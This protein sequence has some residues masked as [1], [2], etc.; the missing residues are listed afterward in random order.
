MMNIAI[1]GGGAMGSVYAALLGS[2]GHAIT[3]LDRN[4]E[5]VRAI[6]AQG[7]RL[8][9]PLGD[10][11]VRVT[12]TL[13]APAV[14]QDLVVLAV[15]AA[16]VASAIT[17]ARPLLGTRTVVLT[18]QNGLGSAD[19]VATLLGPDGGARLAIGIASGFG[20]SLKGLGHAHHNAMQAIRLGAYAGLDRG[21]LDRVAATWRTAGFDA[22]AVD[23]IVA[24][25][26]RKLICNVAYSAP[27]AL[28]GLTVGAVMDDPELGPL[29]RAA[30]R[31]A[32]QVATALGV[33]IA[34]DDPDAHVRA[35]GASMPNAR[36]SALQ[37]LAAGRRS[38][39]DV[40]NGAVPRYGRTVGVATPVNDTLVALVRQ[41][42]RG[43]TPTR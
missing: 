10:R 1:V 12:A 34:V 38:E 28:T 23:D 39:I 9:G 37:D 2:A 14:A 6:T 21:T 31:E 17:A 11:T 40:I 30:A 29:S 35:F 26:W 43:F 5:R 41:R 36:P 18:M 20:A 8:E 13:Q 3:L 19:T 15:K 25:Q 22:E 42:E 7:L 32:W 24:M 16:D 4:P 33:A 27:C